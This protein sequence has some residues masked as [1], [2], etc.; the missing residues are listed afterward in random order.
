MD[1]RRLRHYHC[2]GRYWKWRT[3]LDAMVRVCGVFVVCLLIL[4]ASRIMMEFL[5][6]SECVSWF[7]Q[8]PATRTRDPTDIYVSR[9]RSKVL[10]WPKYRTLGQDGDQFGTWPGLV[11][12]SSPSSSDHSTQLKW[13]RKRWRMVHVVGQEWRDFGGS[14]TCFYDI[15]WIF[16][17]IPSP[18]T[19]G[20]NNLW[21]IGYNLHT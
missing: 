8:L 18:S 20:R 6:W 10:F 16:H 9:G 14:F 4:H 19:D 21:G 17:T 15:R 5:M 13:M 12:L 2:G 3:V 7:N 1:G 11:Q